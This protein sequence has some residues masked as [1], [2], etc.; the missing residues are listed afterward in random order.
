MNARSNYAPGDRVKFHDRS[1]K[2]TRMPRYGTVVG[3]KPGNPATIQLQMDEGSGL[4]TL[5]ANV[6][7]VKTGDVEHCC[8]CNRGADVR[9]YVHGTVVHTCGEH[10]G[11]TDVQLLLQAT[12]QTCPKRIHMAEL[13]RVGTVVDHPLLGLF[14][15]TNRTEA[16]VTGQFANGTTHGYDKAALL[17]HFTLPI[18]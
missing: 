12:A 9:F 14:Y 18:K 1:Y 2:P 6:H 7:P 15:I 10:R 5:A 13:P 8:C 17:E 3:V 16:G 11:L 4:D